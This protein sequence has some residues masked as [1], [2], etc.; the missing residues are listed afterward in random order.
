V[1]EVSCQT[2]DEV[3]VMIALR[4]HKAS[5]LPP[6]KDRQ[7]VLDEIARLRQEADLKRRRDNVITIE[8]RR[9]ASRR[10]VRAIR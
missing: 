9:L 6:G 7:S 2:V 1:R 5:T 3:E 10:N 4:Q 8:S